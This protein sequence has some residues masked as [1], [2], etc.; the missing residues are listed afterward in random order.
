MAEMRWA[1]TAPP[2]ATRAWSM[3]GCILPT[4]R[5]ARPP[6]APPRRA[7]SARAAPPWPPRR[8]CAA[9]SGPEPRPEA[10]PVPAVCC[11]S[12][13][14]LDPV[15]LLPGGSLPALSPSARGGGA[16]RAGTGGDAT[17]ARGTTSPS[18]PAGLLEVASRRLAPGASAGAPAPPPSAPAHGGTG[19][20]LSPPP[21]PEPGPAPV[22]PSRSGRWAPPSGRDSSS[23]ARRGGHSLSACLACAPQVVIPSPAPTPP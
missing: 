14:G 18:P 11:A 7:A 3:P 4:P 19:A 21:V 1:R 13:A 17:C 2:V 16:V 5:G 6:A 9:T 22:P 23:A 8:R 20:A 12:R 15:P 10:T